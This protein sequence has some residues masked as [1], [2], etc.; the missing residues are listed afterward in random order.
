[1]LLSHGAGS[2]L[3]PARAWLAGAAGRH[4]V[5]GMV[6]KAKLAETSTLS[7]APRRSSTTA[8]TGAQVG[9]RTLLRGT[10]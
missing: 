6:I 1:M 4:H 10:Y 7:L 3:M 2:R 5:I 9:H 8:R